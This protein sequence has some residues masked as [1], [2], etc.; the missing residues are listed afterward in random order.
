MAIDYI[1]KS[2]TSHF[3]YGEPQGSDTWPF[4]I[5]L[6]YSMLPLGQIF[7]YETIFPV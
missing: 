1:D 5:L 6:I 7:N 3:P 4:N 2:S